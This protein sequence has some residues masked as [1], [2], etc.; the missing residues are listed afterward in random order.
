MKKHYGLRLIGILM[1]LVCSLAVQVKANV[2]KNVGN[3]N[4]YTIQVGDK[5]T[6]L[7]RD[8]SLAA[9]ITTSTNVTLPGTYYVT[10]KDKSG[11]IQ[12]TC[13]TIPAPKVNQ[14]WYIEKNSQ[15][16]E[17]LKYGLDTYQEEMT[18]RFENGKYTIDTMKNLF[19]NQ[20]D[21]LVMKY[22]K[23]YYS[24]YKLTVYGERNPKVVLK[25]EYGVQDKSRLTKDSVQ[26]DK[27]INNTISSQI[28]SKMTEV[29]REWKLVDYLARK[30]TYGT[31]KAKT[32]HMM[33]GALIDTV[34]VCDGYAKSL[35][36]FLNS[37]GIPTQIVEGMADGIPHAWNLVKLGGN[38]YHVDLTWGDQDSNHIGQ[39]YN[40]VNEKDSYMEL[41]HI[42]DK[43]KYPKANNNAL[44]SINTPTILEGVYRVETKQD[45]DNLKKQFSKDKMRERNII[46]S[47]LSMNKWSLDKILQE[48]VQLAQDEIYYSSYYKYDCLVLNYKY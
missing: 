41:S 32:E 1:I 16:E 15:L 27:M 24:Q 29:E 11:E 36:Y 28:T 44:L 25:L 45:W 46:F 42:W 5:E 20:L 12:I 9:P 8:G 6:F 4:T 22:P 30:I 47:N 21:T 40:Y 34:A 7:S 31:N 17:I 23:L 14:V 26:V 35:M 37:V 38:Y 33:S 39:Y 3:V 48:I 13:F 43:T 19:S 2:L 10:Q 18:F